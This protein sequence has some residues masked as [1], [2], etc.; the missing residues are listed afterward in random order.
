MKHAD[1]AALRLTALGI[2]GADA[3]SP[4]DVVRGQ[5][6]VE[7]F[8]RFKNGV[9]SVLHTEDSVPALAGAGIADS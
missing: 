3:A 4:L 5:T 6:I 8:E 1:L 2:A 9:Q 7:A